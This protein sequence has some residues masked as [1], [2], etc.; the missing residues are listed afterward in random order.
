MGVVYVDDILLISRK[1]DDIAKIKE[2]LMES[3]DVK[4]LGDVKCCLGIEFIRNENGYS[5]HQNRFIQDVLARFEMSDCKPI[6][7]PMDANAKL[8]RNSSSEN[9][10]SNKV[11][12]REL[13]GSLMYI[14]MGTR[15]DRRHGCGHAD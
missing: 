9:E 2:G 11:P 8:S 4:D 5:I 14:A 3:F 15:P 7:T 13:V 10:S 12:Y 6:S 1:L